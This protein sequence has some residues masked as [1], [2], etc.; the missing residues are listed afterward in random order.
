[1]FT[2]Y[3]LK[4]SGGHLYVGVSENL[5]NRILRHKKGN[6]AEFT[7]RNQAFQLVHK[8]LF[9]NLKEARKREAQ[10]KGWRREKKENLI[11]YGKPIF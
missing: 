3:L 1:M 5:Q 10:I 4:S 6:G 9:T 2:V 7:K 11:K 8:E